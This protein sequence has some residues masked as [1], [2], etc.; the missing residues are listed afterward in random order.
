MKSQRLSRGVELKLKL[1]IEAIP[2]LS[3][4]DL[5]LSKIV[6]RIILGPWLSSPLAR[7]T[8]GKMLEALGRSDLKDRIM[9]RRF[10]SGRL[11]VQC[12]TRLTT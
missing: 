6:D 2:G 12:D 3:E 1:K 10:R 11:N 7:G 9:A 4:T 5:S 8:I